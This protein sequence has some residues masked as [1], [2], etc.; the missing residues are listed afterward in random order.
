MILLPIRRSERARRFISAER[1]S[2]ITEV[3]QRRARLVLGWV[4]AWEHRVLLAPYF[5]LFF[6][7]SNLTF[8]VGTNSITMWLSFSVFCLRFFFS[9]FVVVCLKK[10]ARH[11]MYLHSHSPVSLSNGAVGNTWHNLTTTT[12]TTTWLWQYWTTTTEKKA[13][14]KGHAAVRPTHCRLDNDEIC[15]LKYANDEIYHLK[16]ASEEICRC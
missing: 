13:V 6:W 8:A 2:P 9:F 10:K 11:L 14:C 12:T 5:S 15:N 4:T 3:K 1:W 7:V 16:N